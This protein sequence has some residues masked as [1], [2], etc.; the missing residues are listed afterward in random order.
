[1]LGQGLLLMVAGTGKVF[2]FLCLMVVALMALGAY[3]KANEERYRE[4]DSS[5]KSRAGANAENV[6][7][8]VAAIA[9]ALDHMKS[10]TKQ[11]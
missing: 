6:G 3:F 2:V 4:S 5:E 7:S 11:A 8:I 10:N 1:M 9:V